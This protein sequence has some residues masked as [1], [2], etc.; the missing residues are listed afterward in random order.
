M[1]YLRELSHPHVAKFLGACVEAPNLCVLV[2][3][4]SRGSLKDVLENEAIVL[5]AAFKHSLISDVVE[6][7]N[8]LHGSSE[9]KSHGNLK[10]SNCLVDSRLVL[11][12]NIIIVI[13]V[14]IILLYLR[15]SDNLMIFF[16]ERRRVRII[17]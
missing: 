17:Y 1:K 2:E 10:S 9:I 14:I 12:L 3:Y 13:V 4:C 11:S 15:G 6:G 16:T 5:D 8:F 7:L